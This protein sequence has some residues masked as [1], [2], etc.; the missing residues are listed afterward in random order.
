MFII[1]LVCQVLLI[2]MFLMTGGS[3]FAGARFQIEAFNH[4]GLP[5]WFRIITAIVQYVGVA[6]L[7]IGFWFPGVAAWAG[8]W[9]GITMLVAF[10]AHLRVGD[11]ISKAAPAFVLAIIAIVLVFI[12]SGGLLHPFATY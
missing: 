5:Q 6:G 9:L 11:P 12:N 1:T 8:I 10:L 4:L 2:P 7:I 3:M